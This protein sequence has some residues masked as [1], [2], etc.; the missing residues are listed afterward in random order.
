MVSVPL[1]T[2]NNVITTKHRT[3]TSGL[4]YLAWSCGALIAGISAG[5]TAPDSPPSRNQARVVM[6][7]SEE[8][9]LQWRYTL[10][11]PGADWFAVDYDDSGWQLGDGPFGRRGTTRWTTHA[12]WLRRTLQL[13]ADQIPTNPYLVVYHDEDVQVYVNGSLVVARAGFTGR[14]VRLRIPDNPFTEGTNLI[15]VSCVQT[16]GGQSIDVGIVDIREEKSPT[17]EST[18]RADFAVAS[19]PPL[20]KS[21]F[22]VYN[23]PYFS[24]KRWFRDIHLL[25]EL[26]C[27]SLRYDPTWGGHNVGIDM[28]SPQIDGTPDALKY[29]FTDF[30]RFT[31]SLLQRGVKPMYVMAYTPLPLQRTRGNWAEKPTDMEAWRQVC[32]DYAAHWRDTGRQV[33]YF[34]IWNEP[35]NPPFFFQGTM[36]DYFE[37]YK[38]GALGVKEGD[39]EALVGGPA[40]AAWKG[41][42]SWLPGFL[43][44]VSSHSLPLDFLSYHNYGDPIPIIKKAREHLRSHP[45]LGAVP[46][47]L[48]EY[49]SFVPLTHDFD[50]GGPVEQH[51]A[52]AKLLRDFKRLLD[53]E[54][55]TRVY[56][57]MFNDPDT[58]ERVGLVSLEGHR[59]AA[60]NGFKIYADMP[61]SRVHAETSSNDI[62]VMASADNGSAAI[63][64]WNNS[65]RD[66][67]VSI[68][69][70]H[71]PFHG[72]L[73]CF[74][75]D[76]DHASYCD[77]PSSET[78]EP[79]QEKEVGPGPASWQGIIPGG[80]VVYLK[81]TEEKEAR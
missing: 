11:S 19:R 74:R 68:D 25:E 41:D 28:N 12:I 5:H 66:H 60:F 23:C 70:A 15:A 2:M 51:S 48:T 47:M 17:V 29:N 39:P 8:Q 4:W 71:L 57:A 75:I 10:E 50:E 40:V 3:L 30:D 43:E 59:K 49:S 14:Y 27:D 9:P 35:D 31:D 33:P 79:L 44:Y 77:N 67:R 42:D 52:A 55:V 38:Y 18:V 54:D 45:E 78:L 37:I 65:E 56:W 76:R 22:C 80:G 16:T 26:K 81:I 32:R 1:F 7:T 61:V 72:R 46:M 24:M 34:E 64:A 13:T 53:E 63:V 62:D 69:L 21:K 58:N 73:Q 20:L 36:E 6:P